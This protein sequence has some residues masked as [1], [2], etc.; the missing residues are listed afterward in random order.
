MPGEPPRLPG[1]MT[2]TVKPGLLV[3]H[4]SYDGLGRL[5]RTQSPWPNPQEGPIT[6]QVKSERFFYDGIRRIQELV[7]DP[8]LSTK[9]AL[10]SGDP[11]LIEL[12]EADGEV[13][14]EE[15]EAQEGDF[16]FD[17]DASSLKL[18]DGQAGANGSG[19]APE[20]GG[21]PEYEL[22]TYLA[23]EYIWGPGDS[24]AGVDE[25]V[26]YFD[27]N[28]WA[29]WVLQDAGG[30]V[31]AVCDMQG[32]D[33][34]GG[35]AARVC[36]QW[37]YDAYGAA[38]AAEHLA[39]FPQIHCGHKALFFD[40][41]DMGVD[42]SG[43]EPPRLI[44][45]SHLLVHMRNRAYSPQM[46]RF[47]QPD[48]NATALTLIEAASYHGRGLDAMVAAFDVQSLYGD[49][50]N[51][52]EYLGSN[53][54]SRRD[55]LGLSWDPFSMVD[56]YSADDAGSRAAFLERVIGG[57]KTSAYIGATLI[58]MLPFPIISNLGALGASAL[59]GEVSP[60]LAMAGKV[61]GFA[62]LG[63]LS[64]TISKLSYSAARTAISYVSK[65]GL[66]GTAR[67]GMALA[68]RA[69][70]WI[71][72]KIAAA[73]GK[74]CGCFTAA[75]LIWTATG[76]IPIVEVEEGSLVVAQ[77]ESTGLYSLREVLDTTKAYADLL[78]VVTIVHGDGRRERLE[79]TE[80]HP[81]FVPGHGWLRADSLNPG[82]RLS[83]MDE[84]GGGLD[85]GE[86]NP[87]ARD[88]KH[89]Q[90]SVVV[91]IAF[92]QHTTTVY[93]LSVAGLNTYLVGPNGVLVHN[94]RTIRNKHLAGKLHPRSGVPFDADG[95][96]DFS[97]W[98][99][100][101]VTIP[102]GHQGRAADFR[103]ADAIYAASHGRPRPTD[104]T[105]HHHQDGIRLQLVDREVH[106]M[107]GHTGSTPGR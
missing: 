70:G 85:W 37:R 81:F 52:Y 93:N 68:K 17:G 40:R 74:A 84:Q 77:D 69:Y 55:P 61:L 49:G 34:A 22:V 88:R 36:G 1:E 102:S 104:M 95:Y 7:T 39:A 96:P 54:W 41:L 92:V 71:Q 78:V 51:L 19:G 12:A 87:T 72:A 64:V 42:V 6:K 94:C 89:A 44:P 30:D 67:N 58:S 10:L 9:G 33:P 98:T 76:L 105:W 15:E 18:E 79:T 99:K 43:A 29:Y 20:G 26:V 31:V 91:S 21:P 90:S 66:R 107:T 13:L 3:K 62:S 4:Y 100:M 5:V 73:Q 53:P 80:E 97:A 83:V 28:R 14:G 65:H 56:E 24:H 27:A 35:N 45:Y 103:H 75:T 63:A 46:G 60:E 106:M 101:E 86:R 47:M 32:S 48:P 2:F 38:T 11:G 16:V 8:V 57:A 50:M 82:D 25:L 23:R 59:E